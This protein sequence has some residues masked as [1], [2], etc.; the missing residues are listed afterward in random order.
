MKFYFH[1]IDLRKLYPY[2]NGF[3]DRNE[4][5]KGYKNNQRDDED[6]VIT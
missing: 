6:R 3:E 5:L 1:L 4:D 2:S